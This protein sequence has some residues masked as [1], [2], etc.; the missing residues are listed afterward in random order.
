[1]SSRPDLSVPA[2]PGE[3]AAVLFDPGR[4]VVVAT[5]ADR[6]RFLHGIVTAD[7][8]GTPPGRSVHATLLTAK[9]H[10][11]A[12][13][14][15]FVRSDELYLVVPGG[16]GA[17]SAAALGRYAIMDDF[18]ATPASDFT[19]H[20]LLGRDAAQHLAD[21]GVSVNAL[22]DGPPWSHAEVP[23][24]AGPLWVA[25]VRQLGADGYW[26]GGSA[27][28]LTPVLEA[29][30]A[31]GVSALDP[32]AV[33]AARIQA[34]EPAWGRE[35]TEDYFPMEVGL[36]DT[37]DYTKGCFLGQEPIVRIR[38]RGHVNWRLVRLAV[39]AG[40]DGGRAPA[41]GDRLES[42]VKPK[43]GRITSVARRPDGGGVALA[44]A[45]VSVPAG[46]V[47]F[48]VGEDGQRLARATVSEAAAGGANGA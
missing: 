45:H 13:L 28:R 6:V 8:A 43:A 29:L 38:D 11:L 15:I 20:G 42:E 36:A 41:P 27:A 32:N 33:E 3:T 7:V 25:R 30:R 19:I 34:G 4:E 46:A 37:I 10:V 44:L 31:A 12:E 18:V 1:M 26:L 5:G 40:G 2:A 16:Q 23:S 17:T 21:A 24:P 35:I 9:A 14:R 22:A 47:V 48:V 39:E